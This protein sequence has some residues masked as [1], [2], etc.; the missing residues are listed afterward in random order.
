M[1]GIAG[2]IGPESE[3][4]TVQRMIEVQKHRG[5]DGRGAWGKSGEIALGHC[6]LKIIDLSDDGRQ[7]MS[8]ED[9]RYTIV[10]NGEVYNFKDL[11]REMPG[12]KF[13]SETDTEVVLYAYSL[14]GSKCLERFIG[15]YGFAIWDDLEKILFCARD[16]VGIKPFYFSRQGET[17][18]FSSEIRGLL[19]AGIKPEA[20]NG[21]IYDFLMKDYYEHTDETFFLNIRKLPPSHY[22]V[23]ENG[24]PKTPIRYWEFDQQKCNDVSKISVQERDEKFVELALDALRLHLRSDVPVGVALSGGLDSAMLLA[25]L[26][27]TH[28]DPQKVEAFSFVFNDEKY[29]ERPYVEKMIHHTGQRGH[30]VEISP[31]IFI[32][33]TQALCISQ[34]E[35]FAG[36]PIAAYAASFK[37]ARENRFIVMMDG[38]GLDEGLAGYDRFFPAYW[39][40]LFAEGKFEKLDLELS[41]KG[42]MTPGERKRAVFQ[43]SEALRSDSDSGKGQDLTE[44]VRPNCVNTDFSKKYATSYHFFERPFQDNLRNLMYRELRYTKL[45]RALRFRDR[46]SMAVGTELRP[47]FLDHRLLEYEFSLPPEDY[48][49]RGVTKHILRRVGKK[50]LPETIRIAS[51]RSV[52]TPQREWFRNELS[53][54]VRDQIDKPSFWNRG[55]V[56]RKRG[57]KSMEEFF[58]GRG[59][60]SFFL[61]QWINLEL[62]AESFLDDPLKF[63]R[64]Q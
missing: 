37:E 21:I 19:A 10:Y 38:S 17:F 60:N 27:R 32:D 39:V 50:Y 5:P 14:W 29:S 6:R 28:P 43:M 13:R 61:W 9:G 34:E 26:V 35:P 33:D 12:I 18:F 45:P 8:T 47:P 54:W 42:I 46:L 41:A 16:R 2:I 20:N 11:K 25:L 58:R 15:M 4:Q 62:W 30:F 57:K 44:S 51:K 1:C 31:E 56:D 36:L 55:W 64:V 52:Q 3:I 63:T 48:I 7:P 23:V 40:D 53:E 22:M 24:V 59:D 49:S